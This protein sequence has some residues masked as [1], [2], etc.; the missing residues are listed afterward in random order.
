MVVFLT[1]VM[2]YAQDR[3]TSSVMAQFKGMIAQDC[4][5]VRG[6]V[7][8]R[9]PSSELVPGD[10]VKL[11][12]GNR[13]PADLRLL[14]Q[15]ELKVECSSLTG[16]PDAI[17]CATT[18]AHADVREARNVVFNSS[19]VMNGSGLGL[20]VKTGDKTLIGK[21][22][23]L[24]SGIAAVDSSMQRE[25]K[26]F[27]HIIA[28][29]AL[30]SAV[31][32]FVIGVARNHTKAGIVNAFV[33]GFIVVLVANVPEGLPATVVSCL[34]IS[35]KRM[36]GV[37]VFI[38]KSDIIETLG[39]TT[40][41]ASDKTGTLTQNRMTVANTW[42]CGGGAKAQ[43][44]AGGGGDDGGGGSGTLII[45]SLSA[46]RGVPSERVRMT[47]VA[48]L[49]RQATYKNVRNAGAAPPPLPVLGAQH[50]PLMGLPALDPI[51]RTALG[52][53]AQFKS[54]E[55]GA[56]RLEC[57]MAPADGMEGGPEGA[58]VAAPG[59]AAAAVIG[60]G[61]SLAGGHVTSQKSLLLARQDS[62]R[63]FA[64]PQSPA[65]D[66][67]HQPP[68]GAAASSRSLPAAGFAS[69]SPTGRPRFCWFL[70]DPA[71]RL[72][73]IAGINNSAYFLPPP[74]GAPAA[75]AL[76]P[77]AVKALRGE[78]A[79][80][81]DASEAALLRWVDG[82]VAA[83][84]GGIETLRGG[85]EKLHVVPFNS[86]NKWS[87][88][89]V[90][91]GDAAGGHLALLKGAPE[92][93]ITHCTHYLSAG[94]GEA[95]IDAAFRKEWQDAYEAFG[96]AG[97][98]VL[99]FAYAA[100]AAPPGGA[101]AYAAPGGADAIS[102]QDFVFAGL[103]SLVDPPREGVAA[104][105]ARCRT[106][107][108]RV[109]MVTGDHSITA[110]A[111]ARKVGII[112]LP[113]AREVN[114]AVAEGG[115][116][117]GPVGDELRDSRVHAVVRT[118]AELRAMCEADWDAMLRKEEVVFARTTPEQKLEIVEHYQR[119]GH[120]VAVTGDG[121]NDSPAL[122]RANVGVAM[123]G[124]GASDVAREAADIILMD[125]NFASI[126]G[127]IEEGRTLFDNLKKSIA[128]TLAHLWPEL[129]PVFLNLAL[130]MPLA[131]PGLP[132][133]VIDLLT[134]QGPAISFS[135]E[136]A[137]AAVMLLP[138]R[139]VARDR[140]VSRSLLQYAYILT[141]LP[142]MLTCMFAFFMVRNF[143]RP[144]PLPAINA[145]TQTRASTT[146]RPPLHPPSPP[147][148]CQFMF[149]YNSNRR[150]L[151]LASPLRASRGPRPRTGRRVRPTFPW[152]GACCPRPRSWTC[153]TR[154]W[155]RTF[156]PS[157]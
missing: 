42:Q 24:A 81:G 52:R 102:K 98:R 32:L 144:S 149:R 115:A 23:S 71:F 99:G 123:G 133:L 1:C 69:L 155:P 139:D 10:L 82:A 12:L 73:L 61:V 107:S 103:V 147:L 75:G 16:E 142:S 28:K 43:T 117:G 68:H 116:G 97:E 132:I 151:S 36:A 76:P 37:H 156:P 113:T 59:A 106:A 90:A 51:A 5:V 92:V 64:P 87:L 146:S 54:G 110:E 136:K 6:G 153:T 79:V 29:L 72:A 60:V 39:A 38:K 57:A 135:H 143:M 31:V 55:Q 30:L 58:A 94:G 7:E 112:T 145:A 65:L 150:L 127:A 50:P 120:V 15:Q 26:L 46:F 17:A 86:V 118:G 8:A 157:F 138:P 89:V 27:V 109:T 91:D 128:Y 78:R 67:P 45:R 66:L 88:T 131:L 56:G 96:F 2:N 9:I 134:E 13:V 20:V 18:A 104:A 154:R 70:C 101:A 130:D 119:L 41:I 114:A 40:V 140:L 125:N 11:K 148:H 14:A 111:I 77:A 85:F 126:V 35:A 34:T 47:Q 19:L 3:A 4:L 93:V 122:K 84:G 25:V 63:R 121:V 129:L 141:G 124:P 80:E 44:G 48:H 100:F 33:N 108:I 95:L 105:V 62:V 21:V 83:A 152:V 74:E 22:A 49:Q 53:Q 137:E